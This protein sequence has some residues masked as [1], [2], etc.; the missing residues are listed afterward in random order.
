MQGRENT[1]RLSSNTVAVYTQLPQ[2]Q[3]TNPDLFTK[4]TLSNDTVRQIR[5]MS[6]KS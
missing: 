2:I 5:R 6:V 3:V 4:N 1:F